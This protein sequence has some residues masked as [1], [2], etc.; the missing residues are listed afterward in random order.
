MAARIGRIMRHVVATKGWLRSVERSGQIVSR[1]T[2]GRQR[3][4]AMIDALE[5]DM[6][7]PLL[8]ITFCV[9]ARLLGQHA[10][11]IKRLRAQGHDLAA[12]GYFHTDMAK[13]S[14]AEQDEILSVSELQSGHRGG[15]QG[16]L[17][18]L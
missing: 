7:A 11:L 9:T 18:R 5:R 10:D 1:F 2:L 12:H 14:R 3:F 13:K 16:Q 6:P 15:A 4:E 17:L 8:K